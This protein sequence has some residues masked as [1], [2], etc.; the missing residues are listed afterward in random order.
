MPAL[1]HCHFQIARA[2]QKAGWVVSD[3]P[4][5]V[6]DE[7]T[8]TFIVVDI[9]ALNTANGAQAR[10]IY[11]EVKCFPGHNPTQELYIALGQYFFHRTLLS[12][13]AIALP[14]YL[15]VPHTVYDTV[16]NAIVQQLCQEQRIMVIVVDVE[17]ETI[18]Q[19]ID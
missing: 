2:L 9:E 15:A 7:E 13:Q 3:K 18:R 14:F 11:V 4:K 12:R 5:Y 10:R 8:D 1:D 17:T 16:F 19:W 6:T